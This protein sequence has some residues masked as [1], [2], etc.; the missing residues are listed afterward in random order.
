MEIILLQDV[1]T[2]GTSGDILIVAGQEHEIV[3]Q[4]RNL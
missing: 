4:L 3:K 2:L 1:D